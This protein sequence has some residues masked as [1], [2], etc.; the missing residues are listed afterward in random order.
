MTS[1]L[2]KKI[3]IVL[4]TIFE[5]FLIL[6]VSNFVGF[7]FMYSMDYDQREHFSA[8]SYPGK[9]VDCTTLKGVV[10]APETRLI[11]SQLKSV[12]SFYFRL[13]ELHHRICG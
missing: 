7:Y 2:S 11:V 4:L 3:Q 5:L 13:A 6:Y 9:W 12:H 10:K 8:H 1:D